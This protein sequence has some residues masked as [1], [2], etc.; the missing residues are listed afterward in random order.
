LANKR[1]R[2]RGMRRA[3]PCFRFDYCLATRASRES[4]YPARF[5]AP[6]CAEDPGDTAIKRYAYCKANRRP[7]C[8]SKGPKGTGIVGWSSVRVSPRISI[9]SFDSVGREAKKRSC[10]SGFFRPGTAA[11]SIVRARL[12]PFADAFQFPAQARQLK[13]Q[14]AGLVRILEGLVVVA[15]FEKQQAHVIEIIRT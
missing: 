12:F 7:Y 13:S 9:L 1:L 3:R 2:D 6:L 10:R 14:L 4:Q 11:D 15:R 8:A 5:G